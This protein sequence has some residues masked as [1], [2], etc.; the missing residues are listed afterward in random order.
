MGIRKTQ[1]I[2]LSAEAGKFLE[3]NAVK[4]E[5]NIVLCPHCGEK[6]SS[7]M[8]DDEIAEGRKTYGMFEEEIPLSTT[9]L[10]DGRF[11]REI[12][13]AEPWSSGPV[14]FT[15]LWVSNVEKMTAEEFVKPGVA[16][17]NGEIIGQWTD[18][19]IDEYM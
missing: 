4:V 9:R 6:V 18:E 13:Q 3:E 5:K 19:E 8:M 10:K 1:W 14:I 17:N 15:C 16:Q 2:G 12:V 7:C 11:A